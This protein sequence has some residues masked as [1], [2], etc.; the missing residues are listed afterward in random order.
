MHR[1]SVSKRLPFIGLISSCGVRKALNLF[2]VIW[3]KSSYGT[4]SIHCMYVEVS[5]CIHTFEWS[6]CSPWQGR[7]GADKGGSFWGRKPGILTQVSQPSTAQYKTGD[8]LSQYNYK[9]VP[10]VK[11]KSASLAQY[12]TGKK[13]QLSQLSTTQSPDKAKQ[14]SVA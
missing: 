14:S 8:K 2:A 4:Y 6:G 12:K 5:W 13:V 7:R 10:Q 9:T 11:Y 3:F 1:C